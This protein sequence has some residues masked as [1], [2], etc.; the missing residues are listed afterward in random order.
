MS[1]LRYYLQ[2]E[3][4]DLS[5]VTKWQTNCTYTLTNLGGNGDQYLVNLDIIPLH[6][7]YISGQYDQN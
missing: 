5:D 2:F 7:V 4:M 3:G 1:M 6:V